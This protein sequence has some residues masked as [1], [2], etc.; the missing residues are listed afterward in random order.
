MR[1]LDTDINVE[2]TSNT[3][4]IRDKVYQMR[5]AQMQNSA[6]AN[7]Q[8]LNFQGT[9]SEPSA[10]RDCKLRATQMPVNQTF[11]NKQQD[12]RAPFRGESLSMP[13]ANDVKPPTSNHTPEVVAFM[14]ESTSTLPQ[15]VRSD[16]VKPFSDAQ[17][18]A[19]NLQDRQ[20]RSR[21]ALARQQQLLN[22]ESADSMPSV[23]ARP[24][25]VNCRE[26][27]REQCSKTYTQG[28]EEAY[29]LVKKHN[30]GA[31]G[32]TDTATTGAQ[33]QADLFNARQRAGALNAPQS[34]KM[35]A[36]PAADSVD[37]STQ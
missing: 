12:T 13:G 16:P 24:Y 36:I 18:E 34:K 29:A 26:A 5:E 23:L 35:I 21:I 11:F 37:Q 8:T 27:E 6:L 10:A 30:A 2:S 20:L 28:N 14:K 22:F 31:M 1:N 9:K 32:Y 15:H 33:L 17:F 3:V 7:L 19:K 25:T 4:S